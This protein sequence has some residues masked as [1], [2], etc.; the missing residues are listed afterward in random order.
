MKKLVSVILAG[1]ALLPLP[2]SAKNRADVLIRGT[3]I[4]D[5]ASGR[6]IPGQAVA[7]NDGTIVAVGSDA[8]VAAA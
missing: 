6:L 2:A 3:T 7:A 5:V 1:L 8:E 4:V